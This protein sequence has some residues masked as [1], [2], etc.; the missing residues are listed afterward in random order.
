MINKK[1]RMNKK[2]ILIIVGL[3]LMAVIV[4]GFVFLNNPEQS[5]KL[6][7]KCGDGICQL[8]E[9]QKEICPRDCDA[10]LKW[11]PGHYILPTSEEDLNE[12][13]LILANPNNHIAGI[14]GYLLWRDVEIEEDIYDF[15][16][17]EEVLN[18]IKKYDKQLIMQI[19]DRTFKPG[20]KAVPDYIY[21]D[22][23][24]NGGV[25]LKI[26][27]PGGE[28][29]RIWDPAVNERFN[30]LLE[31]LGK[32]FDD[33]HNFGGIVFEESALGIDKNAPGFSWE[34]YANGIIYRNKAAVDAFPNSVVIQ[35]MNWGP[36]E[37]L[38][39]VIEN[40]HQ[41][42]AGMG[43]PDLVPDKGRSLSK[44]RMPAYDYYPLYSGKMPLGAAVQTPN[45]LKDEKNEKGIF[46]LNDFWD[47][48]LNTLKLNYI[49]WSFV[50][51]PWYKFS[52][53]NDILPYINEKDG[54]INDACPENHLLK[55]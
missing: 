13:G 22:S 39:Y 48:G 30:N 9:K 7:S 52:F 16:K 45:L 43:G 5:N 47:M 3:A 24:Y 14:Q 51:Q 11:N 2:T 44:E 49:F 27:T 36:D 20:E 29:S 38:D 12:I 54:K 40:L 41:M 1:V 18:F 31:E 17:I 28:V 50:E 37:F 15:S 26:P 4:L 10:C 6:L 55:N 32:Q 46:T 53:T 23:K 19:S 35:Y 34:T 25:E 42:G 33:D 8:I 21:E